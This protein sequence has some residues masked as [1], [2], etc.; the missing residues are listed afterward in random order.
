MISFIFASLMYSLLTM[1]DC[2]VTI[3]AVKKGR[4]KELNPILCE[5]LAKPDKFILFEVFCWLIV[6]VVS[7]TLWENHWMIGWLV[8][9]GASVWKTALVVRNLEILGGRL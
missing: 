1:A 2:Y 7:F 9:G 4:A 3:V 6:L 8:L 5:L